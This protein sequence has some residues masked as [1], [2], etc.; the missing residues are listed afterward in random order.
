MGSP[1]SKENKFIPLYMFS[2]AVLAVIAPYLSIL[3][4]DLGY[5]PVWVGILLGINSGAG[6]AGPIVFGYLAD[7]TGNYRPV[8][9]TACILPALV[10]FPMILWVHPAASII[11]MS[12]MAIGLRSTVSLVDAI[13]TIQIGRTGN[14]GR[15]RVWG[16]ISFIFVTL[17]LQWTPFLKPASAGNISL[18]IAF[19]SVI[20][21]VPIFI[22]PGAFLRSS[23]EHRTEDSSENAAA[24]AAADSGGGRSF[25]AI[26]MYMFGGF[27]TIF[28]C[29]FS[30][31]SV[32]TYFPLYVTEFLHWNVVGLLF[33]VATASEV[34]IM[35]LSGALVRRFGSL[36]L[37]V[38]A[39]IG[40]VLRLLI[41][42]FLPFKPW[43][44]ASQLLH[45]LC[46]GVFHPAAVHFIAGIFPA[47]KRGIG[48]SV[49][50]ALGSGLPALIGNVAG[51][52]IVEAAGYRFLFALY[53][54]VA[55][56][57][58]LICGLMRLNRSRNT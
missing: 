9:I 1:A 52:A 29:S 8:L 12:L 48:M 4:R 10:I 34:P 3:L 57:A 32:Y 6:I 25:P 53:A 37:L 30:M 15:I 44:I 26:S 56:L 27:A 46:F 21:I 47:R 31:S 40:I 28:L 41:W 35:F 54:A 22:L 17:L 11:F 20:S 39:A 5:S 23:I 24:E 19:T 13:T 58:V 36:P 38:L 49:Y 16:S 7:K 50:M 51:G 43:I 33:A 14:Y 45:S 42:A 2:S 55:G 18:W